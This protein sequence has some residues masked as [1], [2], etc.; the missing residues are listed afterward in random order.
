MANGPSLT[1]GV[2]WS[3]T[4]AASDVRSD[5]Y[6]STPSA[7]STTSASAA[8]ARTS[9]AAT[10][11]TSRALRHA[12]PGASVGAGVSVG[13]ARAEGACPR[14]FGGSRR[15]SRWR[16][17]PRATARA[18]RGCPVSAHTTPAARHSHAHRCA[19]VMTWLR[20]GASPADVARRSGG[21][22]RSK[23]ACAMCEA[24]GVLGADE[25][26]VLHGFLLT[27]RPAACRRTR[28]AVR[29]RRPRG[30][31]RRRRSRSARSARPRDRRRA[32]APRSRRG[33]RRPW[34]CPPSR[35]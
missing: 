11:A 3:A 6:P 18:P 9:P 15:R 22:S 27:R 32:R 8:G 13:A 14:A 35:S 28:S 19:S 24:T 34:A 25:Q 33:G 16:R 10:P 7:S 29:R 5:T 23:S 31:R 1:T 2:G 12:P 4:G 17:G 26:H 20:T 21:A 30:P